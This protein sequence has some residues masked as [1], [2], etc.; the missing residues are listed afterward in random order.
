MRKGDG[1]LCMEIT[2]FSTGCPKC[3]VL[4]KKLDDAGIDYETKTDPDEMI[5]LG[6]K[7]APMLGVGE[8]YYDFSKAIA[9]LRSR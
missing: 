3:K 6:F 5:K 1:D 7:T 8:D 9:W 2:L 4:K